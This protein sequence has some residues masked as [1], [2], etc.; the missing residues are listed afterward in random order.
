M[1]F[2]LAHILYMVIS[3]II[4]ALVM[5]LAY[6]FAKTQKQKDLLLKIFAI[7]TVVIHFSSLYYDY[8]IVKVE[9]PALELPMLMPAYP[10]NICMWLLLIV[11]FAKKDNKFIQLVSNFLAIGGIVCAVIGIVVNEV[12]NSNGM[13]DYDSVRGLLSHSTMLMGCIYLIV[14]KYV[15][16]RVNSVFG[17]LTGL[18]IFIAVGS[19]INLLNKVFDMPSVNSMYLEELPFNTM[20][21]INTV[22]IGVMGIIVTFLI[23][24]TVE[25]FVLAKEERWYYKL[26]HHSNENEEYSLKGEHK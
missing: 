4:T 7:L 17:V 19:L 3:A 11:A 26:R 1:L 6:R 20:P 25:F 23:G 24:A 15:K 18:G 22:T 13:T 2:D 9:N 14:G 16:I 10:C 8:F 21:W 12:Y 5:V